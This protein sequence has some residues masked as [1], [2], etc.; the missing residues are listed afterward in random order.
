MTD[1]KLTEITEIIENFIETPLH[2]K[3][4]ISFEELAHGRI[5]KTYLLKTHHRY[6]LQSIN[7]NVFKNPADVMQNLALI[8]GHLRKTGTTI[9]FLPCKNGEIY[10][11]DKEGVLWRMY[12]YIYGDIYN[13][14]SDFSD[15]KHIG[16]A[17]GS[18]IHRLS[19]FDHNL[20]TD[21]IPNF[22]NTPTYFDA[23]YKAVLQDKMGRARHVKNEIDFAMAYGGFASLLTDMQKNKKMP[24]R[25]VHNDSKMG[26]VITGRDGQICII[27]L[28]TVMPGLVVT[29][30][31][32]AV[33]SLANE[34]ANNDIVL[35]Y[36]AYREGFLKGCGALTDIETAHLPH[37]FKMMTL[38]LGVRYLTD[39]LEGDVYFLSLHEGNNLKRAKHL[40]KLAKE[41]EDKWEELVR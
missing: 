35:I 27:D 4:N 6:I 10:H 41:I 28:D 31:G 26:N 22:H 5:N 39:Y 2:S 15:I 23:L 8:T 37:G 25:V 12:E 11:I 3:K 18:F 34:S 29:D 30:F 7:T 16:H 33:R 13:S 1:I 20:L 38:E 21:V 9:N 32:D 40:F 36:N 24:T 19:D 17:Y 14:S